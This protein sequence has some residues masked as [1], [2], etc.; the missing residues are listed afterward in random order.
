MATRALP[1]VSPSWASRVEG[2]TNS[3]ETGTPTWGLTPLEASNWASSSISERLTGSH[4]PKGPA[5]GLLC[6]AEC[7]GPSTQ[8]PVLGPWGVYLCPRSGDRPC[9]PDFE[10]LPRCFRETVETRVVPEG[11]SRA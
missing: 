1:Q 5:E 8:A 7:K 3:V 2:S 6:E 10:S 9:I 4:D 11:R